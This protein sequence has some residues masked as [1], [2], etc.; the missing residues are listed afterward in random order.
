MAQA[1]SSSA[2]STQHGFWTS[3][4]I[5]LAALFCAA[6]A[7]CTLV[8]EFPLLAGVTWLK[9]DPS[10]IIALLAGF[11]FGPAMGAVVSILPYFVHFGTQ[12]GVYGV[13]MAIVSTLAYVL[14]SS[15]VYKKTHATVPALVLGAVISV[16]ACIG[17]NLVVTPLYTGMSIDAVA[18][19]IVPALLPFNLIKVVINGV[20][21]RAALPALSKAV[22]RE[23]SSL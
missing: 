13:I 14:P 12:S 5:A 11:I 18:A 8:V 21:T 10:G 22:T 1:T 7:L 3:K 19:L 20:A 4:N 9:Y 17:A 23:E 6:A 2:N 16:A 15:L